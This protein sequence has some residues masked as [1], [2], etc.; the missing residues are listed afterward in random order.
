M[1]V[2]VQTP[3]GQVRVEVQDSWTLA[4]FKRAVDFYEKPKTI[5]DCAHLSPNAKAILKEPAT[6][7]SLALKFNAS[8]RT[9]RPA[10]EISSP[11]VPAS[12]P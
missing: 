12:A 10:S 9:K 1:L 4:D 7:S 11:T 8:L 5:A 6:P 2:R 3:D